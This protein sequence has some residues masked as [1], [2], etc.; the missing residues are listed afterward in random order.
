MT[1]KNVV[2]GKDVTVRSQSDSKP[3]RQ[4][5]SAKIVAVALNKFTTEKEARH[6][7]VT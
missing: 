3:A 5:S 6:G 2:P 1:G 7:K 4:R